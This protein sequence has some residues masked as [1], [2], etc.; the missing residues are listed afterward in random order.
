M[1]QDNPLFPFFSFLFLSA[2]DLEELFGFIAELL[3]KY[4]S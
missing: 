4:V 1:Y 3:E 2:C